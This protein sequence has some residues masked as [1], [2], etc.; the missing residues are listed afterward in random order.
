VLKKKLIQTLVKDRLHLED[1][2]TVGFCSRGERLGTTLNTM[3]CGN[4]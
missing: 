3:K 4:L 2:T 1:T